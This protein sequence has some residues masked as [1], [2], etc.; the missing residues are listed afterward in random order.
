[1]LTKTSFAI[2]A[3][4]SLGLLTMTTTA[5]ADYGNCQ[6]SY[7]QYGGQNCN[8][9][10]NLSIDKKVQNPST[11]AFV[12]NLGSNDVKYNPSSN[13]TFQI[14]VT[15]TGTISATN[16][17]VKDTLPTNVEYV[18]G[19]GS[20]DANTKVFSYT[21]GQLNPNETKEF[22]ITAKTPA[23]DKLATNPSCMTNTA[24]ITATN[25]N[26]ATD[27]AQFCVQKGNPT[28]KGGNPTTTKGGTPVFP[29]PTVTTTP[30]TGP[31]MLSLVGLIGSGLIGSLLR[32]RASK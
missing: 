22:T 26:G 23:D 12:D 31:E 29:T 19:P 3:G 28:T 17:V 10:I 1:M 14:K 27:T 5:F 20:F 13:I 30:K 8:P 6:T 25:A 32:K 16:V 21:V 9:A 2:A 15:N 11:N 24:T 18:S 4:L 7:G